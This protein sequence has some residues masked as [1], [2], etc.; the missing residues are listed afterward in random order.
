MIHIDYDRNAWVQNSPKWDGRPGA[1][2]IEI[3]LPLRSSEACTIRERTPAIISKRQWTATCYWRIHS[4][5]GCMSGVGSKAYFKLYTNFCLFGSEQ[6]GRSW[7]KFIAS[8]QPIACITLASAS[9]DKLSRK[10]TK[11]NL[12]LEAGKPIAV[13]EPTPKTWE[14]LKPSDKGD[15]QTF[16]PLTN[17]GPQVNRFEIWDLRF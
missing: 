1:G 3:P 10:V 8:K 13:L 15:S 12:S 16:P 9:K 5:T 4:C 11:N 6:S 17:L 14:S 7:S 2:V